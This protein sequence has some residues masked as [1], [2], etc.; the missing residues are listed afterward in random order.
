MEN[1]TLKELFYIKSFLF[2]VGWLV[3]W[4]GDNKTTK[5]PIYLFNT[6]KLKTCKEGVCPIFKRTR[7]S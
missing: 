2:G 3:G 1:S 7:R 5:T 6:R 4:F